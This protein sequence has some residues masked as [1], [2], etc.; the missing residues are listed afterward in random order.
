MSRILVTGATGTIG[1][2]LLPL[3]AEKGAE[4]RALT[5]NA[6]AALPAGVELCVGNLTFALDLGYALDGVD[7]VFILTEGA[8]LA[9]KDALVAQIAAE[10]GVK[11]IVK[12]S[13][14]SA[15]HGAKDPITQWHLAGESAIKTSG[16]AWTMLRPNAFMS[17]AL[18]WAVSIAGAGCVE[19]PFMDRPTSCVDPLDIARV[20]AEVLTA[21]GH[22]GQHYNLTGPEPLSIRSQ[23]G[24]L[25]DE[26]GRPIEAAELTRQQAVER[27][28]RFG[29]AQQMAEAVV[30]MFASAEDPRNA[31]I[32][33]DIESITGHRAST[34]RHWVRRNVDAFSHPKSAWR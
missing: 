33:G 5:R 15:S 1:S 13:V 31:E 18:N 32:S 16:L 27:L 6:G 30:A 17:N 22:D 19:A 8:D 3:L 23:V 26:L 34:F 25:A 11:C 21:P 12:L 2:L 7:V 24:I 28:S 10:S 29:M 14:L 4:V 9:R 20:A